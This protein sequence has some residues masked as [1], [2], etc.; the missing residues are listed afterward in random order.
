[1]GHVVQES[2]VVSL[3]AVLSAS[4]EVLGTVLCVP[5]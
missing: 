3:A 1:M 5:W 2:T 4:H